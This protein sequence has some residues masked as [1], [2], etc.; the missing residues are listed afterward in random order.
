MQAPLLSPRDAPLASPRTR[1]GASGFDGGV[2]DGAWTSKRR[3]AE[4]AAKAGGKVDRESEKLGADEKISKE[5]ETPLNGIGRPDRNPSEPTSQTSPANGSGAISTVNG[6]SAR[7]PSA[8]P[9]SATSPPT[10][11]GNGPPPGLP[12]LAGIEWSYL[13]PQGQVQGTISPIIFI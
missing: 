12:D 4:A 11:V 2:L 10:V 3:A 1:I 13:D 6:T 9:E 8:S 5:E 7:Q